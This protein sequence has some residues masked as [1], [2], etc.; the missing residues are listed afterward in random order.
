MDKKIKQYADTGDLTSLK[1]IFVDSLDVD[2][3]F[4]QYEEAYNYCK[5]VPGLLEQHVELTPLINDASQWTETYWVTLKMDLKKNF[6]DQRMSHMRKVAKVLL[7]D[8]VQRILEERQA[9][10]KAASAA[11]AQPAPR[12][13]PRPVSPAPEVRSALP[14]KAEQERRARQEESARIEAENR[15]I[16]A[17]QEAKKRA[18]AAR[19]AALEKENQRFERQQRTESGAFPKKA[20]G[21]AIAV[22]AVVLVVVFL[23]LKLRNPA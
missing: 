18:A 1:Y 5:A 20:V 10:S 11:P 8:K 23:L 17:E 19:A 9:A 16:A 13:S 14:S 15:R 21:I 22:V 4:E 12:T 2:P 6:S 7:A 3:T